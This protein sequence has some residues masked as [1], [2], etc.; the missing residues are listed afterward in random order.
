M[1][2]DAPTQSGTKDAEPRGADR[3]KHKRAALKL[4]VRFLL[5]N[6]SEHSGVVTDISLGG[7]AIQSEAQPDP[8]SIVIAYVEGFGR[9]EGMVSRLNGKGFAVRLTLSAIKREKLEERL[10]ANKKT[11]PHEGRKHEREATATATRIIRSD[12]RSL[13]CRVIDLSLGGVSVE[14]AEWPALGEQVVV[15]KMRGRVVR[16]HELGIAIE[17]TDIPPSRGSLAEQLVAADRSAA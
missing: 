4:G 12:G 15:G 2:K 11:S 17:F 14:A 7:M 5:A 8:G 9:L 16:H 6:G 10:S 1:T 13:P 3:R